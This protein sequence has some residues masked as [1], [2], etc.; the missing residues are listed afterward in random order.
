MLSGLARRERAR[1]GEYQ[2]SGRDGDVGAEVDPFECD[3]GQRRPDRETDL[4]RQ[5]EPAHGATQ[6]SP[7]DGF[8]DRAEK[9]RLLSAG[10]KP[11]DD[12]P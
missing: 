12:L 4:H 1:D 10:G 8:G 5:R 11:A 6:A 2:K 9:G 7:R 3:A